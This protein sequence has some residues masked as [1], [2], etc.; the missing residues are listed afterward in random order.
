MVGSTDSEEVVVTKR[1]SHNFAMIVSLYIIVL[2]AFLFEE[3]ITVLV[4]NF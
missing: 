2:A 3:G 1:P 4:H